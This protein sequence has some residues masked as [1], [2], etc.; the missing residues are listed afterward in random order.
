MTFAD[1]LNSL[2]ET[3]PD[4][5]T[6]LAYTTAA[7]AQGVS[8]AGKPLSAPYLSQLRGGRPG[9]VSIDVVVGLAKWFDVSVDYFV[10]DAE[11]SERVRGKD[12][13]LGLPDDGAVEIA[14]RS[15]DLSESSRARVLALTELLRR[16]E[17]LGGAPDA[18]AGEPT[19]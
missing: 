6:G 7:V 11:Y 19:E 5:A 13:N 3:K 2:F 10:E 17:Q 1:R 9:K 18:S 12:S 8:K 4:P 14:Y 15:A 16:A